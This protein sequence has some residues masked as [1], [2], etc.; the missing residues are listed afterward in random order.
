MKK[1]DLIMRR[2]IGAAV[3]LAT[4]AIIGAGCGQ[5]STG[6]TT[7][8]N[9]AD[10]NTATSE[11]S[12]KKD[13]SLEEFA[14]NASNMEEGT[15]EDADNIEGSAE[16]DNKEE[17]EEADTADTEET[18]TESEED[19]IPALK[20]SVEKTM[21]C[22]FG[23][24]ITGQEPWDIENWNIVTKHFNCVTLGNEL[25]P[26]SL[27]G[28]SNAKC[29]GT[30]EVEL[31][32]ETITVPVLSFKNPE[33]IL[34]KILKWNETH[35]DQSLQV[36]GHVLLWH[37]QTPEWFFHEDYDKE[38][39]YVTAEVMDKRQEWYIK[40]VLEHF[41]G[42]DSKYKDLFYGWDV[43]NEAISDS[44]G[45]YRTDTERPDEDLSQDTHGG[46]SSWWHVYQ[47]ESFIINAFKYANKYAPE[48]LELY[49]NDYNECDTKKRGG[50]IK[51]LEA[52]K[53]EEGAPGEGTRLTAMGMQGHYSVSGPSS[54]EFENAIKAYG[55]VVENIQITEWDLSASD[56]YDSSDPESVDAEYEKM[57]KQY[58][59]LYYALRSAQNSGAA[60]VTGMTFW[61][62]IDKYSWLQ[63]RSNVGGG[64]KTGQSQCPLLFDSKYEPK[65]CFW[66]FAETD[67][68]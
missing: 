42:E 44:T 30:E 16:T 20:D 46:N 18:D 19:T 39:P 43:V 47:D 67:A 45:T 35:P 33:K 49:Y 31:N 1:Y 2:K 56:Q 53:A 9:I 7:E 52:V 63:F 13:E 38:K 40:S 48:S 57:R 66:V 32:G 26:D 28:Y 55:E 14:E 65:P 6:G 25:K 11:E 61:G 64:N 36:R 21:G 60:K 29:P 59:L 22:R 34:D 41:V 3:L 15:T 24:A 5:S 68:E 37:S 51:L 4:A 17:T 58:N 27:F 23:C 50:I 10:E 12:D 8:T 54:T 62:T